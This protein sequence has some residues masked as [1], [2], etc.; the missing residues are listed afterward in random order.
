MDEEGIGVSAGLSGRTGSLSH[1]EGVPVRLGDRTAG[2]SDGDGLD[3]WVGLLDCGSKSPSGAKD[4]GSCVGL[5]VNTNGLS[6]WLRRRQPLHW[7]G[8]WHLP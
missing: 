5:F 1:D 6:D 7:V 3:I 4:V 2:A 8:Q